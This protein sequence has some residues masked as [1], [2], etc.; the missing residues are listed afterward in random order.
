M[1]KTTFTD[2][3][4]ELENRALVV[5]QNERYFVTPLPR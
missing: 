5:K 3:R 4:R 1:A 2:A